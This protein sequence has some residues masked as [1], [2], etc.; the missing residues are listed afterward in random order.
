M[1]TSRVREVD[2]KP[3]F[4]VA[5][6]A[7]LAFGPYLL[8]FARRLWMADHYSFFPLF[9]GV[10]AYLGYSR[11]QEDGPFRAN[12]STTNCLKWVLPALLLAVAIWLRRPWLAAVGSVFALRAFA[13]Q[14]GGREYF[15]SVRLIWFA[16]W[17]CIPL[18]FNLDRGLIQ[19]MQHFASRSASWI[20]DFLGYRHLLTG[21][22][23]NF[24]GRA[25]E[26]EEACS[27]V[28]SLFAS[29]A[30]VAV[31]GVVRRRG[32]L[33]TFG[34]L[35]A[36]VFWVL[37]MNVARILLVVIAEVDFGIPLAAGLPHELAGYV[38][39]ALVVLLVIS[40]DRFLMFVLPER[41]EFSKGGSTKSDLLARFDAIRIPSGAFLASGVSVFLLL[42]GVWL[43]RP[44]AASV[45]LR[46][47][48]TRLTLERSA[49]LDEIQ[50]WKLKSFDVVERDVG[51][52]NGEVSYLWVFEKGGLTSTIAVD[53]PFGA[54]HDLGSC[55]TG[56]GW[57][58]SKARD[59]RLDF[60]GEKV[61]GSELEMEDSAGQYG[62]V[63]FTVVEQD[64]AAVS[65]PAVRIGGTG[66]P[67]LQGGL[68]S[69]L[70]PRNERESGAVFC[71]Q[72]FSTVSLG[73]SPRER[74]QHRDLLTAVV[75]MLRG[76]LATVR[77]SE[78]EVVQ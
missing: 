73:F 69:L 66:G 53:G 7:L 35:I 11:W 77:G 18:P 13:Y 36:A 42:F 28:H 21:V 58:L 44:A 74:E 43:V 8:G 14:F 41:S 10:L 55:Y 12:F 38:I 32:F 27:G 75:A 33:R 47:S 62:H 26:V 39:F 9:L 17:L 52:I 48:G 65:P 78:G 22:L 24:P 37:A 19:E 3:L 49:L 29:L 72:A 25:F 15:Q 70:T 61:I 6:A 68:T 71:I 16:I 5:L 23:L 56:G 20:L 64:G 2:R 57:V 63:V 31:Y 34:L 51:D 46:V 45:P 59:V 54:W 50:G 60:P 76:R 4:I 30:G 40:T 1:A 67:R